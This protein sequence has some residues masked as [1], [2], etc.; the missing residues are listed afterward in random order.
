MLNKNVK[1]K[2]AT[3]QSEVR[4]IQGMPNILDGKN[5]DMVASKT[6]EGVVMYIKVDGKWWKFA[7]A[8]PASKRGQ[9]RKLSKGKAPKGIFSTIELLGKPKARNELGNVNGHITTKRGLAGDITVQLN[10]RAKIASTTNW[11]FANGDYGLNSTST[12]TST[13]STIAVGVS[14]YSAIGAIIPYDVTVEC[15]SSL[16]GDSLGLSGSGTQYLGIWTT[17]GGSTAVTQNTG[18]GNATYTLKYMLS[19]TGTVSANT[20]NHR[21]ELK[22]SASFD[23]NAG[24][25]VILASRNTAASST[26]I[27]NAA[28][29]LYCKLR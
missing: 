11:V 24:D 7:D 20:L 29:T 28:S 18:T 9:S 19:K 1:T 16:W 8:L 25:W 15:I 5:G 12:A 14:S 13:G 3:K 6:A 23:L 27:H 26:A 21:V 10:Y 4:I 17:P 2:L 22:S